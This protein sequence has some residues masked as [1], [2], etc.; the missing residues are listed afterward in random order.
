MCDPFLNHENILTL[1]SI[2]LGEESPEGGRKTPQKRLLILQGRSA[3]LSG[4]SLHWGGG[5]IAFFDRMRADSV[6]RGNGAE[7][8]SHCLR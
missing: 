4:K 3:C 7:G 2:T 6:K 1:E 5:I 8:K